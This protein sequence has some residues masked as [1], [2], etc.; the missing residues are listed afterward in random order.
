M[1]T[2]KKT[3][4]KAPAAVAVPQ[5]RDDCAA[6]IR[7]LGDRLRDIAR[8][9]LQMNDAIAVITAERQPR[10]DALREQTKGLTS[11]IQT[12]CEANREALTDGNKVKFANLITGEVTWR[13]RPP[14]VRVQSAD[15]VIETLQRLGLDRFVRTKEEVNKEAILNEPDAVRGVA[16]ITVVSGVEDFAVTP[17]EQEAS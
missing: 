11:A 9:E 6:M 15:A 13:A 8:E 14:S 10:I 4:V 17:F 16:G 5:T 12:W 1:S 2:T 3:K 7:T